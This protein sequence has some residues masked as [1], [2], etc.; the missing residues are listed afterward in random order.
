MSLWAPPPPSLPL[1]RERRKSRGWKNARFAQKRKPDLATSTLHL[2]ASR[3]DC[4]MSRRVDR[5]RR[6]REASSPSARTL[7]S[8]LAAA[9]NVASRNDTRRDNDDTLLFPRCGIRLLSSDCKLIVQTGSVPLLA[10]RFK[11][12]FRTARTSRGIAI[13]CRVLTNCGYAS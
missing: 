9:G 11:R 7:L 2:F 8:E 6:Y 10:G 13:S 3:L 5:A 12:C 4:P 1:A